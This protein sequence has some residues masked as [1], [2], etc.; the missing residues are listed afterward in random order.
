MTAKMLA[1][2]LLA[3][4]L[5]ATAPMTAKAQNADALVTF[6]S[7]KPE[8]ALDLAKAALQICRDAGYQVAIAV[9]D[10]GGL[11]QVALRDRYA[12]PH[13]LDTATRKAW[14]AVTFRTTTLDLNNLA[15]EDPVMRNLTN[16]TNALALGGGVPV[17]AGGNL[18]GAIGISGAP[19]A[20][21]DHECAN[22]AIET[23]QGFLDF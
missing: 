4:L 14:T 8:V 10:R 11:T 18:V 2:G 21:L 15:A 12:G 3:L 9:V 23:I 22:K 13:T 16:V 17:L 20:A 5:S 19:G 7:L 6:E 1:A